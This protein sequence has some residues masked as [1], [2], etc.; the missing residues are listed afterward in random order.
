MGAPH[1]D[2]GASGSTREFST[3]RAIRASLPA[4]WRRA[5]HPMNTDLPTPDTATDGRARHLRR[6]RWAAAAG[7]AL[8]VAAVVLALRFSDWGGLLKTVVEQLRAGGP[9]L[10]FGA[11][12]LLPAIGFPLMP[13][14]VAAGPTF[15]PELGIGPTTLLAVGAVAVNTALSYAL[16]AS[17]FRPAIAGF[18]RWLGY[19]LPTIRDRRPWQLILLVRL[20]PG[21]PFWV[22][23]YALGV[24]RAPFALYLLLSTAIPALYIVPTIL[25]L[26]ALASGRGRLALLAFAVL[27]FAAALIAL[28]RRASAARV[29][30]PA[31][32]RV[33]P[34]VPK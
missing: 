29:E 6:R 8:L 5:A 18:A 34:G 11:M 4:F 16:A 20:A 10:F 27:G 23:S 30:K 7:V 3:D 19:E 33:E 32:N 12:A 14:T 22:Q 13:F 17:A 21:L 26:N 28:L 9:A 24:I 2:A 25:G 15:G 1:P 31:T